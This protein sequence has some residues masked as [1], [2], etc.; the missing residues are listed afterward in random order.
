V[1]QQINTTQ[2]C[3]SVFRSRSEHYMYG[4]QIPRRPLLLPFLRIEPS[5]RWAKISVWRK[6]ARKAQRRRCE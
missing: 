4:Y 1:Y 5:W 3:W 2:T 6:E